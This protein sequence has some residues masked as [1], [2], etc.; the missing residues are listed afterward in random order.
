MADC[1][2]TLCCSNTYMTQN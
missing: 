1:D 2:S